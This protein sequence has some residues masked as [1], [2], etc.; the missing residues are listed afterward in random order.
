M[1]HSYFD[2]CCAKRMVVKV[3]QRKI[4]ADI[5]TDYCVLLKPIEDQGRVGKLFS[6]P[7]RSWTTTACVAHVWLLC[8]CAMMIWANWASNKPAAFRLL[9]FCSKIGH[10]RCYSSLDSNKIS[11]IIANK[12]IMFEILQII[13]EKGH[14]WSISSFEQWNHFIINYEWYFLSNIL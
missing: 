10:W 7:K 13:A 14:R 5:I 3:T 12:N 11:S 4:I 8:W 6:I 1:A 9:P 2:P